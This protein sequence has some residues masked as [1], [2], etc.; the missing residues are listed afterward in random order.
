MNKLI[1]DGFAGLNKEGKIVDI[2][3]NPE[4]A[5]IGL[6]DTRAKN[7]LREIVALK[8]QRAGLDDQ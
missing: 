4:A 5:R 3:E 7:L 6:S 2:R 8:K 1:K